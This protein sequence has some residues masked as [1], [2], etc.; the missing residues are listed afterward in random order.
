[1]TNRVMRVRG[2]LGLSRLSA[3]SEKGSDVI[4]TDSR[5]TAR[6]APSEGRPAETL[7][8]VGPVLAAAKVGATAPMKISVKAVLR[9]KAR[10]LPEAKARVFIG[11]CSLR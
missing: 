9:T 4:D 5:A 8:N 7:I 11:L 10:R 2:S 3:E 6:V 1:M